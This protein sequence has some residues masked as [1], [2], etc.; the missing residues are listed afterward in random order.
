MNRKLKLTLYTFQSVNVHRAAAWILGEYAT[1]VDD[2]E[3]VMKEVRAG[4][5]EL[6][7]VEDEMRRAAGDQSEEAAQPAPGQSGAAQ[8]LTSDGT[9]VTQ[10]AFTSAV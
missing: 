4:L 8:K 3:Q 1:S 6:P 7:L 5:G 9:Y 10:S 2:I